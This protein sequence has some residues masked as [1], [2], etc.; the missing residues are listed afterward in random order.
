MVMDDIQALEARHVLQTYRRQPI[1]LRARRRRPPVRRRGPRVLRPAVGHRRRVARPRATAG[2][3][4]RSP[5][6]RE[7]LMHTSNLFFHP[8]QGQLAERLTQSV[9]AVARVL[10]QQRHRSGRGVPEVRAPL[11]VH[12]R[13]EAPGDRRAR[14]VVPRPHDRRAVGHLGRALSRA[15]RAAAARRHASSRPTTPRRWRR[16][17]RATPRRSSSSRFRAKAACAR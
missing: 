3:R 8:L 15:V 9:G 14:G 6:R 11:L 5:T 16:R 7:T 10:L 17:S 12:A 2:C 1:T 4:A 13:R